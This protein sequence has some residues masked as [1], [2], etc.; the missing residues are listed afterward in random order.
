MSICRW[1]VRGT[2]WWDQR[3]IILIHGLSVPALVWGPLVAPLVVTE[4]RVLVYDWYGP[5]YSAAPVAASYD[6]Q[7]YVTQ[8]ALLLQHVGWTRT[9]LAGV[10]MGGAIAA[11]FVESFPMLA[12]ACA[13]SS[14]PLVPAA[15]PISVDTQVDEEAPDEDVEMKGDADADVDM[16]DM[17]VR[18]PLDNLGGEAPTSILYAQVPHP[19]AQSFMHITE[20]PRPTTPPAG[21]SGTT[22]DA[23][24]GRSVAA[25]ALV[26]SLLT[27]SPDP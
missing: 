14:P 5:G 25:Q 13:I 21:A 2:G 23:A 11:A 17:R 3:E 7:L 16:D 10:S 19:Q 9:R 12:E 24:Y 1:G 4:H 18:V 20:V 6:A 15:I 8:L 27:G 26:A 22:A